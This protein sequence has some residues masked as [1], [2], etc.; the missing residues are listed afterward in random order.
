MA[1]LPV[2]GDSADLESVTFSLCRDVDDFTPLFVEVEELLDRATVR[3][4]YFS[5]EWIEAWWK[6]RDSRP[7]WRG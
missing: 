2:R 3:N 4:P 7:E 1:E 5:P 6:R